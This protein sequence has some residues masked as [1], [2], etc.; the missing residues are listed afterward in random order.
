MDMK[1]HEYSNGEITVIWKPSLCT[2]SGICVRLL[3]SVYKPGKKPWINV[4]NATTAQLKAQVDKCPSG[5]LSYRE[6]E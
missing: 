1:Q 5:A 4:G 3:P 6:N 2:H